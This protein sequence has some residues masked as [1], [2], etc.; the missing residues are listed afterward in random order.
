[1]PSLFTIYSGRAVTDPGSGRGLSED[2]VSHCRKRSGWRFP[3]TESNHIASTHHI[4][5][6]NRCAENL[7]NRLCFWLYY[8]A[9]YG[10]GPIHELRPGRIQVCR[11]LFNLFD[12]GPEVG[13][14]NYSVEHH[15]V[16]TGQ[17][18]Y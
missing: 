2:Q 15:Q 8:L 11:Y 17:S 16:L 13:N 3:C 12:P 10:V 5:G 4:A 6:L 18:S 14:V 7:G 9:R 1:M